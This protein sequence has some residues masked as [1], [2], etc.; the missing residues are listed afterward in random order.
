MEQIKEIVRRE[1]EMFDQVDNEGGRAPCQE[2]Y[3]TFEIMRTSQFMAWPEELRAGYLKDLIA[4]EAAGRNLL[5]EKYA[6]M[7]VCTSP[8]QYA[9]M[10]ADLPH[11][12]AER[13]KIIE[14]I[15]SIQ[16]TW[17]EQ[18]AAAYPRLSGQARPIHTEADQPDDTSFETYLRG[19]LQTYSEATL[20]LY[21]RMI[22]AFAREEKN[23]TE[24]IMKYTVSQYGYDSLEEAEA[25]QE[26]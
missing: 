19:E 13:H 20:L 18:F 15:I 22:A 7:M 2:D 26:K 8:Q 5:M 16:L 1:W 12:S 11:I 10:E 17:R 3:E 4:A 24:E 21:G 6:R 23:L 9:W 14:A 25:K